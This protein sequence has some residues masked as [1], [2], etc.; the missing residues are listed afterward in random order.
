[1]CVFQ[2]NDMGVGVGGG[3]EVRPIPPRA[4]G[5]HTCYTYTDDVVCTRANEE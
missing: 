4:V 1:M 3:V 2:K 5:I